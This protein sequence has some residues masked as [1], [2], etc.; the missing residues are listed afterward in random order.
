MVIV[1]IYILLIFLITSFFPIFGQ[2]RRIPII[3]ST[4]LYH[5]PQDPDDHYDL[6][7]LACLPELEVKAVVFD[8]ATF[9]RGP[10]EVGIAALEQMAVISGRAIPPQ[11]LGLREPLNSTS[12]KAQDQPEEYQK[13][14]DL[15][16]RTL[17]ESEQK[18][19]MFLVGSC[20]DFAAAFNRAPELFREKVSSIYVNAG[21]GPD[22]L[23]TEWNVKLDPYAYVCLIESGLPI[24]WCP[25]F[26][27][28]RL[29][30]PQEVIEKKA[31]NTYFIIPDQT[32]LLEHAPL[33][34]KNFFDY[35]LNESTEE[36]IGFLKNNI[37]QIS[38]T[39][40]NMWCTAPFLHAA[41]RKIYHADDGYIAYQNNLAEQLGPRGKE[42]EV[43][44]FEPISVCQEKM[45]T[46]DFMGK[47]V[48]VPLFV[49]KEQTLAPS[50]QIF[51]Y[52]N[53]A[54]NT[55]MTSIV[56][57]LFEQ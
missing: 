33:D 20:R 55:I 25:C 56:S 23:Q 16:L 52:T 48:A 45:Q 4:D 37:P 47:E 40:R 13:G 12:D 17:K 26:S 46:D 3:Y 2:E 54:F 27:E 32:K 19:M 18:V 21:N 11:A 10:E 14:V 1:R 50:L 39:P 22:G 5:P 8:Q 6:A 44:T 49:K 31:F 28:Y 35:A 51:R 57:N 29:S 7:L 36:P 9:W 41:G 15:I 24:Y 30:T 42:V 38:S 43:Y 53:P 34:L